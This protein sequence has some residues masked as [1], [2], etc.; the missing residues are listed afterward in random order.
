MG[1]ITSGRM[2]RYTHLV[3]HAQPCD[4]VLHH[5]AEGVEQRH[6]CADADDVAASAAAQA[7]LGDGEG[8]ELAHA[9]AVR[10]RLR[11]A[12][13]CG[14]AAVEERDGVCRRE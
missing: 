7:Q 13:V 10:R 9:R 5:L 14:A 11:R 12:V 8:C 4:A 2:Y 1:V 3:H 6:L